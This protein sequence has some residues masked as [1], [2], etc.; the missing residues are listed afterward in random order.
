MT[1][2]GLWLKRRLLSKMNLAQC[3]A[4]GVLTAW[5]IHADCERGKAPVQVGPFCLRCDEA[6][7]QY[8]K[9]SWWVL[10]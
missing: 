3:D 6:R 5:Y 9:P 7:L 8:V 4:C 2:F 10:S 1:P